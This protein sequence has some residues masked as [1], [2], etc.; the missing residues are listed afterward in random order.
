MQ[1]ISIQQSTKNQLL[2]AGLILIFLLSAG[3]S[4]TMMHADPSLKLGLGLTPEGGCAMALMSDLP[5]LMSIND[6]LELWQRTFTSFLPGAIL[7]A[8][9]ATLYY[10]LARWT[11]RYLLYATPGVLTRQHYKNKNP[12]DKIFSFWEELFSSG[13]L[14]ARVYA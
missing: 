3:F 4:L 13:I 7:L 9:V 6:H 10:L 12:L 8:L 1:L 11:A 5:C 2:S 14:H